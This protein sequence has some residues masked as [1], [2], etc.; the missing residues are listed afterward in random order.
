MKKRFTLL[1]FFLLIPLQA[2]IE[3][4]GGTNFN[5][6]ISNGD[7]TPRDLDG[8]DFG[9]INVGATK[10]VTFQ[11]KAV[12]SVET[13]IV[14]EDGAAWSISSGAG[15]TILQ[16]GATKNFTVKLEPTAAGYKTANIVINSSNNFN[17]KVEGTA[18]GEPEIK[19]EGR[20]N[21]LTNY[22]NISDNDT[23]PSSPDGTEFG[24]QGVSDGAVSRTFRIENTGSEQLTI[25]SITENS[26][27]F[28]ITGGTDCRRS[29]P[30]ANLHG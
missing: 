19:V 2:A 24:E 12:G 4:R 20:L 14:T 26:T 5:T 22:V 23:S 6:L 27:Q 29:Q 15:L 18:V 17:F 11:M 28:S 30:N 16:P 21:S 7:T 13:V 9:D 10:T 8:T 25:D 1:F 3:V